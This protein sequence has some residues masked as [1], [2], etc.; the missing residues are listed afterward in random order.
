MLE[1][2]ARAVQ[3]EPEGAEG[4]AQSSSGPPLLG[5]GLG[6]VTDRRRGLLLANVR[7]PKTFVGV[8]TLDVQE[9]AARAEGADAER[10]VGA[11]G[12]VPAAALGGTLLGGVVDEQAAAAVVAVASRVVAAT[13][14]GLV[15]GV[16]EGHVELVEAVG[17]LAALGVLAEAGG[18]V[19]GA[20][21]RLVAGGADAGDE[22]RGGR[23]YQG[24]EGLG[25]GEAAIFPTT[26]SIQPFSGQ[27]VVHQLLVLAGRQEQVVTTGLR[28]VNN[29][30]TTYQVKPTM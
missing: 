27:Q 6:G 14:L 12:D 23:L 15:F 19:A 25:Q 18:R 22:W 26:I 30:N 7:R 9:V 1:A 16:A 13:Q 21:L 10:A 17:E 11:A 2:T 4:A 3:T 29:T 20:E 5:L 28:K 24:K 8:N